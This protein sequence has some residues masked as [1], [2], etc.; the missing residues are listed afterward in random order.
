VWWTAEAS[1]N[2]VNRAVDFTNVA[3]ANFP[4]SHLH[5]MTTPLL[6]PERYKTDVKRWWLHPGFHFQVNI[7]ARYVAH[8][9]GVPLLDW[10]MMA[11]SVHDL[12]L[13]T[14]DGI[15]YT[16]LIASEM[17]NLMLHI[18]AQFPARL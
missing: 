4:T 18:A 17:V 3:N 5:W 7:L 1:K 14:D 13:F 10:E 15:H 6:L 11:A 8:K 12:K 16:G 2:W 9:M